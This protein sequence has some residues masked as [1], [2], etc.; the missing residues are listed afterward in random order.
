MKMLLT[1]KLIYQVGLGSLLQCL[2]STRLESQFL[3]YLMCDFTYQ[4]LEWQFGEEKVGS[5]LIAPNFSK[6]DS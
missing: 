3:I 2:Q 1:F 6:S 4:P 5:L